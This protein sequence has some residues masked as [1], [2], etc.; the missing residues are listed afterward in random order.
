MLSRSR[1]STA[2]RSSTEG[3]AGGGTSRTGPVRL[4]FDDLNFPRG[5]AVDSSGNLLIGDWSTQGGRLLKST[6]GATAPAVLR[7]TGLQG[8]CATTVNGH[9]DL[10]VLDNCSNAG[11]TLLKI[12]AGSTTS[13]SRRQRHRRRH[14]RQPVPRLQQQ[15]RVLGWRYGAR[16]PPTPPNYPIGAQ[17]LSDLHSGARPDGATAPIPLT[18]NNML[19]QSDG[20]A[21]D[22]RSLLDTLQLAGMSVA[23][24]R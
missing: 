9:G 12:P 5:L 11:S 6:A 4:Q 16:A 18:F 7:I 15:V 21:V 2:R 1:M 13:A 3:S 19:N 24:Q 17:L 8:P 23:R 22:P 14:R 20:L 10:Y